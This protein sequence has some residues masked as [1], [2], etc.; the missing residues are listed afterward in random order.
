MLGDSSVAGFPARPG[1][2]RGGTGSRMTQRLPHTGKQRG[3][4]AF[5]LQSAELPWHEQ[6]TKVTCVRE[7]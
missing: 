2:H 6:V 5:V 3:F 1:A 4:P 7:L